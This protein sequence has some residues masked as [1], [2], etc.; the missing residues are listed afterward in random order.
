MT[1]PHP[2]VPP[3]R[4]NL[5]VRVIAAV[6]PMLIQPVLGRIVRRIAARHPSIFDRL[7]DCR[8]ATFVIDPRDMPFVLILRP[9]P[10]RPQLYS[11]RRD[12]LPDHRACISGDFLTLLELVDADADGDALFFSRDLVVTGDTEAVVRLRNALDDVEGSIAG[13]A[14]ALF[15]PPG[16][17][18]LSRLRS[19]A[20]TVP[21]KEGS[22]AI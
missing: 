20:A 7:G 14:A 12:A 19:A 22:H 4:P 9:D 16:Q 17:F 10:R 11:A 3:P 15:G 21:T 5:A 13:D 8:T 6:P 2:T 18:L 1:G